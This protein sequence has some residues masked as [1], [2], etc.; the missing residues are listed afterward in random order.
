[1]IGGD[2]REHRG[3][4]DLREAVG[5]GIADATQITSAQDLGLPVLGDADGVGD[6]GGCRRL[7]AGDYHHADTDILAGGDGVGN[8]FARRIVKTHQTQKRQP[9]VRILARVRDCLSA[10]ARTRKPS[11]TISWFRR[12]QSSR[13]PSSVSKVSP[14]SPP[15]LSL[16]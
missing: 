8:G 4:Q 10:T 7:I 16:G 11:P 13:M 15:T 12:S 2:P 6:V 14:S 5:T 3:V 1:M 9:V